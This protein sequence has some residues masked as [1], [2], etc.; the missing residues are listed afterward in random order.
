MRC[1]YE[2]MSENCDWRE[3]T[4]DK[5]LLDKLQSKRRIFSM[6]IDFLFPPNIVIRVRRPN[7]DQGSIENCIR[8]KVLLGFKATFRAGG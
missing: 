6:T 2:I 7:R 5:E 4:N 3:R 1:D 8:A